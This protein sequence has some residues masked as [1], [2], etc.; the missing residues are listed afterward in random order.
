MQLLAAVD[1]DSTTPLA[2]VLVATAGRLRRGM[3]AIVITP[4]LDTTWVR[5]LATLRS[6]GVASVAVTLDAAAYDRVAAAHER[7]DAG[8][9]SGD[10][11]AEADE[12]RAK[13]VR[14]LRHALAEYELKSYV[15]TPG[16]PL[17][18][19]LVR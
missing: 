4:S 18:E 12:A 17:G 6:R 7:S 19:V 3:T 1:G 11:D 16:R 2:E 5:P 9:T 15:I 13:R 10:Q 14:A 8:L